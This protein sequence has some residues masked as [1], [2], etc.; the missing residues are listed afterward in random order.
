MHEVH[1]VRDSYFIGSQEIL[2]I[3]IIYEQRYTFGMLR[4][5]F[6]HASGHSF[7]TGFYFHGKE[8]AFQVDKSTSNLPSRQ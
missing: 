6:F 3:C 1:E 7:T 8:F 2:A 5:K 4:K